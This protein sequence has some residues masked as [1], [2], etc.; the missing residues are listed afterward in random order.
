MNDKLKE[1]AL[2]N[3][4]YDCI[5][6]PYDKHNTGDQHGSVMDDLER[7]G[8][9]IIQECIGRIALVGLSNEENEA[10]AW[11]VETAISQIKN[12]FGIV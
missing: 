11:T 3:G 10:V 8:E 9:A 1:I 5:T 6:D 12:H 4:I 2:S 7:F